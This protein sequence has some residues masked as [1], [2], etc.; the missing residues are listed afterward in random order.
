MLMLFNENIHVHDCNH[1][2]LSIFT[3]FTLYLI[4]RYY[5]PYNYR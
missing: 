3:I 1:E 2:Y 4:I 5:R